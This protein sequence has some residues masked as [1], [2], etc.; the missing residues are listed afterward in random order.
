MN[1]FSL[2]GFLFLWSLLAEFMISK[3]VAKLVKNLQIIWI[4]DLILY[5]QNHY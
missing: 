1:E 5:Y 3:I 4:E 2:L